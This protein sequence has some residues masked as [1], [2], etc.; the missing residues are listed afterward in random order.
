MKVYIESE[1]GQP[2]DIN[3]FAAQQGFREIGFECILFENLDDIELD[4]SWPV[5]GYVGTVI[6]AIERL[7][8][9]RPSVLGF[10]DSLMELTGRKLWT[11]NLRKL[12]RAVTFPIF[13]KP[14]VREKVFAGLV[15]QSQQDL[16][17]LDHLDA[18]LDILASEVVL[19]ASEY[20]VFVLRGRA[21]GCRHYKGDFRKF[22]EFEV[23][24]LTIS[25]FQGAPIGY[26]VDL[27]ITNE[28]QT[29]L[30]EV[31]DGFSVAAYGLTPRLYARFLE[32]R[33]V[34]MVQQA[35]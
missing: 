2:A 30:V 27:G 35:R 13:I 19:F 7:G 16:A 24:D 28:G 10:P 26:V 33:W 23:A 9:P 21:V 6:R 31:N 15:L 3:F 20:R 4:A 34:E 29:L 5:V 8:C 32:A 11:T 22:P 14:L 17:R 1:D 25:Q 18:S 12:R